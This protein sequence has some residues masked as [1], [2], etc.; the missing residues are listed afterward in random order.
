[1]EWQ[2]IVLALVSTAAVAWL[3]Y[4]LGARRRHGTTV[5]AQVEAP[6]SG[7][8][9]ATA[10]DSTLETPADQPE[11]LIVV[12][13]DNRN[14][15]FAVGETREVESL[16]VTLMTSPPQLGHHAATLR[17]AVDG[18]RG[19]GELSGRLVLVDDKTAAAIR[20]GKMVQ[21]K[22]GEMLAI[23][24][25]A[26]GKFQSIARLRQVGGALA[27]VSA[28][29]NALSAMALQA[30]L[31][32]IERKLTAIADSIVGFARE[33]MLQ[34]HATTRGAQDV[35]FE[36]YRTAQS[37]G[38]LTA[39]NWSQIS[40]LGHVIR[41][42]IQGDRQRLSEVVTEL[43]LAVR[44]ADIA[45]RVPEA[46]TKVQEVS[47]AYAALSESTRAW[48]Q[49]SG[50]RLW[51]FTTT[52]EPAL[53]AYRREL[54]QFIRDSHHTIGD[55]GERATDAALK[56]D[57]ARWYRRV[58]HPLINKR[59]TA[60]RERAVTDLARA[61]WAPLELRPPS[62]ELTLFRNHAR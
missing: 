12:A 13:T 58:Q 49:F 1:M 18:V 24:K 7:L 39:A 2:L 42:Q 55:L 56:L 15:F 53:E 46:L 17:A 33:Q 22:G 11:G 19:Y 37:A 23:A 10:S 57:E 5:P 48:V 20:A 25:G 52:N 44:K 16:G 62:R 61:D 8:A 43:E 14:E 50:L 26:D 34:W 6:P 60:S 4:R 31:D 9:G 41:T 51:H 30:Q 59:L 35:L 28:L 47:S 45:A 54:E 29:S 27:S 36:V 32:R 40:A 3:A 38:E 21:D